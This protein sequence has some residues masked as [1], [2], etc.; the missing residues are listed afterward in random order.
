MLAFI[1]YFYD[2]LFRTEDAWPEN[3]PRADVPKLLGGYLEGYDHGDDRTAWFD[4]IRALAEANGYAAKPKDFKKNP[5]LYKGHAGDVSTV[6]RIALT[7][8]KN[9]PDLWEIQQILGEARTRSRIVA[10]AVAA[11]AAR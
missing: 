5:A 7:G 9:S 1:G 2:E 3:V 10:A 8:R 4:R 11:S 6:I